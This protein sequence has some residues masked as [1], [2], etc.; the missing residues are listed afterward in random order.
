M[1]LR[2]Q[3]WARL[4]LVVCFRSRRFMLRSQ[5]ELN[6]S[7]LLI[8][9]VVYMSFHLLGVLY[10]MYFSIYSIIMALCKTCDMP[11]CL[12]C[13]HRSSCNKYVQSPNDSHAILTS[14]SLR[15]QHHLL[16][17]PVCLLLYHFL[18]NQHWALQ[19]PFIW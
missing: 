2:E 8:W 16:V 5:D 7:F 4:I 17:L 10:L 15:H 1:L 9:W 3:P 13:A 14:N 18:I 6:N 19:P 11:N 12:H